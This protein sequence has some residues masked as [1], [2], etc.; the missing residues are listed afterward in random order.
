[1]AGTPG[2]APELMFPAFCKLNKIDC[3]GITI[4]QVD[5]PSKVSALLTK[6][7]QATFLYAVTQP[8]MIEDQIGG[9]IDV[10]YYSDYGLNLLSNG[11]VVNSE[12]IDKNPDLVKRFLGATVKS[13]Q[14]AIDHQDEAVAAFTKVTDKPK[15]SVARQQL[16]T[17]LSLLTTPR[18]KARPL[19]WMSRDDWKE[20]ISYLEEYGGIPQ[21]IVPDRIYTNAF[22]DTR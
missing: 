5:I 11:I 16:K 22:V 13:W 20:T 10:L 4:V 3:S 2:S 14:Y 18:S 8:P 7:V 21:G 15:P 1:M 17:T 9:P 12:V 6:R 19:G